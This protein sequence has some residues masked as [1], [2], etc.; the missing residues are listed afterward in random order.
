MDEH[1]MGQLSLQATTTPTTTPPPAPFAAPSAAPPT[2]PAT[3]PTATPTATPSTTPTT[4]LALAPRVHA[5]QQEKPL[6]GE[7]LAR[8]LESSPAC[9]N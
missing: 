9:H 2:A 8:H 3:A 5:P 6:Q 7:T 4:T 1:A